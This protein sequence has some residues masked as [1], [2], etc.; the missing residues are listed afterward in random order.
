MSASPLSP[1]DIRA[2]AQVHQELGPEYGDAVVES[3]LERI[4]EEIAVRI[5]AR[6]SRLSPARTRNVE[7]AILAHRGA[8]LAG[9]AI[10]ALVAGTPLTVFAFGLTD[11]AGK[12]QWLVLIWIVVVLTFVA[13][14]IGAGTVG[15]RARDRG[16]T[17]RATGAAGTGVR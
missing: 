10:G 4:D 7:P 2:A 17:E 15:R 9:A 13:A 1:D 11:G 16:R 12:S 6:L 14:A 5:D 8:L 3:F